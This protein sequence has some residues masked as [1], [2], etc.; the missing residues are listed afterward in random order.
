MDKHPNGSTVRLPRT[1]STE[2][3]QAPIAHCA[4]TNEEIDRALYVEPDPYDVRVIRAGSLN[5]FT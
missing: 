2:L 5:R 4:L 3:G 1:P